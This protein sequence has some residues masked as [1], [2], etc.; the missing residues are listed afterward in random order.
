VNFQRS[1]TVGAG[2]SYRV[3]QEVPPIPRS[4]L[5]K[6]RDAVVTRLVK[7]SLA[8]HAAQSPPPLPHKLLAVKVHGMGD[9]IMVRSILEH[10]CHFRNDLKLGVLVGPSTRE[11]MTLGSEFVTH[12]YDPESRGLAVIASELRHIRRQRY[13][14][15]LNFEQMSLAGTVFLRA[16]AI[17]T[18]LGFLPLSNSPKGLF[19]THSVQFRQQDTMW[20]SFIRLAQMICPDLPEDLSIVPLK[21][22]EQADRDV[23][24]WW[25][26]K[27]GEK[28]IRAVG[29]H[30]GCGKGMKYRQWPVR[31]FICLANA[32]RSAVQDVVVILTG[33]VGEQLLIREFVDSYRGPVVDASGEGSVERT[34]LILKRCDLLVSV[35]TGAMH[36][37]AAMGTPTV[38][39]FGPNTPKHWAPVGPRATSVYHTTVP[40]SP[41]I[42]SYTDSRP[43]SCTYREKSRCMLDIEAQ[44][45]LDAAK[46]VIVGD[47]LRA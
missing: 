3:E 9:S 22:G 37:A 41:C 16:T 13:D 17:P 1:G 31:R 7:Y 38:G 24:L 43:L 29:L 12:N 45:V 33:T 5:S 11:V 4:L 10:L 30:L 23:T 46:G 2:E 28:P 8:R 32:I 14:A 47:W 36:L 18:R 40:C 44:T 20:K 34:A 21:C 42:N 15:V 19:L 25:S 27:V 35:D 39:L 6:T 26:S